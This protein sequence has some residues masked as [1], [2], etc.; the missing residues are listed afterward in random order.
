MGRIEVYVRGCLCFLTAFVMG[1]M[2][3]EI[4]N[5]KTERNTAPEET[6]NTEFLKSET[7]WQ[8]HVPQ[9]SERTS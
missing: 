8:N 1:R 7:A 6:V 4:D 2:I 9:D 5:T 3:G